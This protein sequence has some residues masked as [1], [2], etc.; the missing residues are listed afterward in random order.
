MSLYFISAVVLGWAYSESCLV[1]NNAN[2]GEIVTLSYDD[3]LS[4][5]QNG[6]VRDPLTITE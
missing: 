3:A 4:Q 1:R 6:Q 5:L 2:F